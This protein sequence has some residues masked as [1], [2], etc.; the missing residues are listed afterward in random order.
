M[1][2]NPVIYEHD[3]G[4]FFIED[5]RGVNLESNRDEGRHTVSVFL[6]YGIAHIE[7]NT[8][9]RAIECVNEIKDVLRSTLTP[10]G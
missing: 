9:I 3:Q 7:F 4:F 6:N 2:P 1:N 5:I 8:K 10:E